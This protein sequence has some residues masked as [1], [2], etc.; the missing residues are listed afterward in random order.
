MFQTFS[1]KLRTTK[2]TG[3]NTYRE[4]RKQNTESR[5]GIRD[6]GTKRFWK[7]GQ[8]M[9]KVHLD[10]LQSSDTGLRNRQSS[11]RGFRNR[12][13]M[14]PP[15]NSEKLVSYH[16]TTRRHNPE[17]KDMN[18]HPEDVGSIDFWNVGILPQHYTAS[19]PRRPRLEKVLLSVM[20]TSQVNIPRNK[21][22]CFYY[23]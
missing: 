11:N 18:L 10:G 21:C 12:Q 1:L 4:R 20:N 22:Y 8:R 7:H 5:C 16:N 15:W 23:N 19:Q 6:C 2:R 17:D 3:H 14:L 9:D 13:S